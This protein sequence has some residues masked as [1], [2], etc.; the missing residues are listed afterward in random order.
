MATAPNALLA[1]NGRVRQ[2][3]LAGRVRQVGSSG[4]FKDGSED[5]ILEWNAARR[6][7]QKALKRIA[8][9]RARMR[10]ACRA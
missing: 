6:E 5:G 9:A 2:A 1:Q 8:H 7:L 4:L 3:M 10:Q